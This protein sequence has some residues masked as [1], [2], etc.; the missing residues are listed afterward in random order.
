MMIYS[1]GLRVSE[2]AALKIQHI[3]SKTMRVFVQGGKGDKD[4]YTLLSDACV[5]TKIRCGATCGKWAL[6][7]GIKVSTFSG[8]SV[9]SIRG[10]IV[11][12]YVG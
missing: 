5:F 8:K 3:D 2:A 1:S 12:P 10:G 11:P 9:G 7:A 6:S 4:R